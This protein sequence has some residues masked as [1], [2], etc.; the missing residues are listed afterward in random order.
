MGKSSARSVL[1]QLIFATIIF[2][3]LKKKKKKSKLSVI[4]TMQVFRESLL[5]TT[6]EYVIL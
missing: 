1:T 2:F 4:E 5:F 6:G 3:L